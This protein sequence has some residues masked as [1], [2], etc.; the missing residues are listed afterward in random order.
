MTEQEYRE[1]MI[2]EIAD[3]K[4]SFKNLA[5]TLTQKMDAL[6]ERMEMT[7]SN[8]EGRMKGR[9]EL[10]E[11]DMVGL[12]QR[13]DEKNEVISSRIN[14]VEACEEECQN[15]R[16]VINSTID[17]KFSI[18]ENR[19]EIDH[20]IITSMSTIIKIMGAVGTLI[21]AA[22]LYAFFELVMR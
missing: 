5:D 1:R 9:H 15:R 22:A 12:A 20:D 2:A 8:T 4:S 10:L 17:K 6:E 7:L 14:K 13:V 11:K 16:Q 21:G 18:L 19:I 3:L